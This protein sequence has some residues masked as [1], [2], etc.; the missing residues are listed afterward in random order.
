MALAEHHQ[1]MLANRQTDVL[2]ATHVYGWTWNKF[3]PEGHRALFSPDSLHHAK[4]SKLAEV[5]G[6]QSADENDALSIDWDVRL[7]QYENKIEFAWPL[8]EKFSISFYCLKDGWLAFPSGSRSEQ[9]AWED[10]KLRPY[11]LASTQQTE[12]DAAFGETAS[13]AICRAVIRYLKYHK[14]I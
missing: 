8:A 6:F 1:Q 12:R 11:F 2:I 10:G 13:Q 4:S 3:G 9:P 14:K 5:C 7:P